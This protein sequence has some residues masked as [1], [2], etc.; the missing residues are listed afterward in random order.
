MKIMGA[1]VEK[2]AQ[3]IATNVAGIAIPVADLAGVEM[4]DALTT[5]GWVAASTVVIRLAALAWLIAH[6]AEV[7]EHAA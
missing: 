4:P 3:W 5:F 1:K 2:P 6:R 7:E